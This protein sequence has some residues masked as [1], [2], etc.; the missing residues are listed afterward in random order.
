MPLVR[1]IGTTIIK[2]DSVQ[3][4]LV[5]ASVYLEK[6]GFFKWKDISYNDS[7][8]NIAYTTKIVGIVTYMVEVCSYNASIFKVNIY[9]QEPMEV[10]SDTHEYLLNIFNGLIWHIN[11]DIQEVAKNRLVAEYII[12]RRRIRLGCVFITIIFIIVASL[13]IM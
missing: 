6:Y 9:S 11:S 4:I 8:H 2:T 5:P 3:D 10:D 1:S 7:I 12:R 13:T